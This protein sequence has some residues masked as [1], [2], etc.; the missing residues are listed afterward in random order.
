MGSAAQ[1]SNPSCSLPFCSLPLYS[2]A[3]K[4]TFRAALFLS[5]S[6]I[7]LLLLALVLRISLSLLQVLVRHSTDLNDSRKSG[8]IKEAGYKGGEV[9]DRYS[10]SRESRRGKRARAVATTTLMTARQSLLATVTGFV[11]WCSVTPLPIAAVLLTPPVTVISRL[12]TNS[13]PDHCAH[14][15]GREGGGQP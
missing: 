6:V 12:S 11:N 3:P 10:G 2:S 8:R 9:N 1:L 13:A 7:L 15:H 14:E 4:R 5:P